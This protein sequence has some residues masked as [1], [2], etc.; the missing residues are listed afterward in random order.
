M[1]HI[2][3]RAKRATNPEALNDLIV[4]IESNHSKKQIDDLCLEHEK[5]VK[6]QAIIGNII[7]VTGA[8]VAGILALSG[9]PSL[10]D[11]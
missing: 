9:S 2:I 6:K 3:E 7:G 10:R 8:S 1:E 5:S 4:E 11:S